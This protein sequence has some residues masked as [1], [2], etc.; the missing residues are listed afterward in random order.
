M[1]LECLK[2][3]LILSGWWDKERRRGGKQEGSGKHTDFVEVGVGRRAG[4]GPKMHGSSWEKCQW[5]D[6]TSWQKK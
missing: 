6:K 3:A 2:L 5:D 1:Y 4:L